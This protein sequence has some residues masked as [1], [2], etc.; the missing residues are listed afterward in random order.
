MAKRQT[1]TELWLQGDGGPRTVPAGTTNE[2]GGNLRSEGRPVLLRR[3][4]LGL[5]EGYSTTSSTIVPLQ[6][7]GYAVV[8]TVVDGK[9]IGEA[10]AYRHF[11]ETGEYWGKAS[12]ISGAEDIADSVHERHAE[13]NFDEWNAFASSSLPALAPDLRE[14]ISQALRDD[15]R[16]TVRGE[17]PAAPETQ[18]DDYGGSTRRRTGAIGGHANRRTARARFAAGWYHDAQGNWVDPRRRKPVDLGSMPFGGS[19]NAEVAKAMEKRANMNRFLLTSSAPMI[20]DSKG[21]VVGVGG[22]LRTDNTGPN[23]GVHRWGDLLTGQKRQ[24]DAEFDADLKDAAAVVAAEGR[25]LRHKQATQRVANAPAV[26]LSKLSIEDLGQLSRN[27]Q[28][29]NDPGHAARRN[30]ANAAA[31]ASDP[32]GAAHLVDFSETDP[33]KLKRGAAHSTESIVKK[34][35]SG[36]TAASAVKTLQTVKISDIAGEGARRADEGITRMGAAAADAGRHLAKGRA[37]ISH[38]DE[39][40]ARSRALLAETDA[41]LA[42]NRETKADREAATANPQTVTQNTG[43]LAPVVTGRNAGTGSGSSEGGPATTPGRQVI[44]PSGPLPGGMA[45][46]RIDVGRIQPELTG[47]TREDNFR[48]AMADEEARR[49]QQRSRNP[50]EAA[51]R[52]GRAKRAA[53]LGGMSSGPRTSGAGLRSFGGLHFAAVPGTGGQKSVSSAHSAADANWLASRNDQ[54][55]ADSGATGPYA[56]ADARARAI[57][58]GDVRPDAAAGAE[59]VAAY[60]RRKQAFDRTSKN[61]RGD[62]WYESP[63][64]GSGQFFH[65]PKTFTYWR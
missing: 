4:P 57:M 51:L 40:L 25:S 9:D 49:A 3:N 29:F 44:D 41:F 10:G 58:S 12:T 21:R 56:L 65:W 30:Q 39:V 48:E 23:I 28:N 37:A 45:T 61:Y 1:R 27:I 50:A 35:M 47:S 64:A 31:R 42:K 26:D 53:V 6:G 38:A 14:E 17:G 36:D 46:P 20:R 7:G 19:Q 34:T 24:A 59:M 52:G 22:G 32:S 60:G 62:Y 33:A 11:R 43:V 18:M 13:L 8:P 5:V 15:A 16:A 54:W 63:A 55:A 2:W